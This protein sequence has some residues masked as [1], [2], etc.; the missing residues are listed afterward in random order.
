M[1]KNIFIAA[2]FLVCANIANAQSN[3]FTK[4]GTVSFLSKTPLENIQG[5]NKKSRC[6]LNTD[7]G[8]IDIALLQKAFEFEKALL[9]EHYN[10]NYVESDKFPKATFKGKIENLSAINFKKDGIYNANISGDLTMH[11]VTKNVVTPA[12][13][14]V[15]NGNLSAHALFSILLADYKIAIPAA[16]KDKIS[17]DI[18]ITVDVNLEPSA[19]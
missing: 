8:Q 16:V 11:G 7:T 19:K 2:L 4:T 5:I 15:K 6:I 10:E 13:F 12:V 17:S 9:M 18:K 1:I 3:F 14:T